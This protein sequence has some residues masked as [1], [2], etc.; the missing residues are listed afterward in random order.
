VSQISFVLTF[1]AWELH[2]EACSLPQLHGLPVDH[3]RNLVD[4]L[5]GL[6]AGAPKP[7]RRSGSP[8][9]PG[10]PQCGSMATACRRTRSQPCCCRCSGWR[11]RRLARPAH[12]KIRSANFHERESWHCPSGPFVG[13]GAAAVHLSLLTN[14]RSGVETLGRAHTA[15]RR[16]GAQP[17]HQVRCELQGRVA[18]E[19][20]GQNEPKKKRSGSQGGQL[21][22]RRHI[23][24]LPYTGLCR[25]PARTGSIFHSQNA[26]PRAFAQRSTCT[27]M[28]FRV[29][30]QQTLDDAELGANFGDRMVVCCR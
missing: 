2:D 30:L 17:A 12:S 20:D 4:R 6:R 22:E 10:T 28:A 9:T 23:Q 21:G 26:S 13:T 27:K 29:A 5:P 25:S 14:S 15:R 24:S 1:A 7:P 19:G 18:Q 16:A 3:L 11:F 8:R